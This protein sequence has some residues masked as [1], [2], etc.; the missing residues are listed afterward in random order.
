MKITVKKGSIESAPKGYVRISFTEKSKGTKRF[1]KENGAETLEIG[2]GK[3]SEMNLRKFRTL[4]RA[5]VN[6]AKANKIKKIALQFD[7][8]PKLCENLKG[9]APEEVSQLIAENFEMAN[10]EFNT[11]KTKPKEGF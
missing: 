7:A 1:I 6:T 4:C 5:I 10:F 8:T 2:A 11:F 3:G 9:K